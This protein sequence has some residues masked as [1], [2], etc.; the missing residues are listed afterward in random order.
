MA[1]RAIQRI[2]EKGACSKCQ[3]ERFGTRVRGGFLCEECVRIFMI[4]KQLWDFP[5]EYREHFIVE[6]GL[7]RR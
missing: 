5:G 1:N 2:V 6:E 7:N 4:R 3:E